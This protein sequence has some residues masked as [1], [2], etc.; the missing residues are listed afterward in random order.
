MAMKTSVS[1]PGI[2]RDFLYESVAAVYLIAVVV[3][4]WKAALATSLFLAAGIV[5][6]LL[7]FKNKADAAA[8]VAAAVLGTP[9]EILCVKYGVWTY[10]APGL[11]LG[12]PIW[13]P[14]IWA[15]LFCLFRRLTRTLL[16]VADQ[17][18]P[19]PYRLPRRLCFALL[20]ALILAYY[21]TISLAI[22]R[23][24]AIVYTVIMLIA[25]FFWRAERDILIF[26]IGGILGTFGEYVCMRLGFWHYHFP[27]L[28]SIGLPISLPMAWGLSA[29][30]IGRI[31]SIWENK[32]PIH[33]S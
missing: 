31:A 22:Y 18:W 7:K 21:I 32:R 11:V 27:Y 16:K 4:L 2:V 20:A 33:G 13:L 28:K 19:A 12:V 9:S 29:V 8:M 1:S 5:F 10:E 17:L 6:W 30:I 23:H 25:V 14:L 3:L 26:I 24:I 15:S